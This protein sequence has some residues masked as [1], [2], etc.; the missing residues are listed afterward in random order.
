MPRYRFVP[1]RPDYPA[2]S[3]AHFA[4]AALSYC[5]EQMPD[6]RSSFAAE[7]RLDTLR[8]IATISLLL[9]RWFEP[10]PVAGMHL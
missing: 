10:P 3:V 5:V 9:E 4:S 8:M 1:P 7:L 6:Q 2:A